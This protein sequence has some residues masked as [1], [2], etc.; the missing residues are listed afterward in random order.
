MQAEKIRLNL[1]CVDGGFQ[2]Y[3]YFQIVDSKGD[4]IE[5]K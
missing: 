5:D 3:T 4:G 2:P 1:Q